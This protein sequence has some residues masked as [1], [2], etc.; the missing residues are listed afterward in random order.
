MAGPRR[1]T[2]KR[3]PS[4][5]DLGVIHKVAVSLEKG[6]FNDYVDLLQDNRKLLWKGFLSGLAKGVGAVVGATIIVAVLVMLLG[7]LGDTLP[8]KFGDFFQN[9]S[10]NIQT[11]GK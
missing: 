1:Q 3:G 9:T 2:A 8:G 6:R 10:E 7:V 4:D 11:P 5:R